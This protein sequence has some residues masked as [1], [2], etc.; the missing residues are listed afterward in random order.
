MEPA[1]QAIEVTTLIPFQD[2]ERYP[3]AQSKKSGTISKPT[4]I[5]LSYASDVKRFLAELER[6]SGFF[7]RKSGVNSRKL[8]RVP[9]AESTEL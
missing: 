5:L 7:S 6:K 9:V 2:D 4:Q 8:A 3:G 1:K